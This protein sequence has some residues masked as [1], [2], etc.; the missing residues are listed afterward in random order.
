[1]DKLRFAPGQGTA[2]PDVRMLSDED[3]ARA[4]EEGEQKSG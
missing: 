2:D 3:L 1:M 4:K